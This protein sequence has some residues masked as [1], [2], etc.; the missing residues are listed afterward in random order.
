MMELSLTRS[1]RI[2]ALVVIFFVSIGSWASSSLA[3]ESGSTLSVA[4]TIS[5][6]CQEMNISVTPDQAKQWESDVRLRI[7]AVDNKIASIY[8]IPATSESSCLLNRA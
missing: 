2:F 1:S 3:F 5:D 6:V 7:Q 8:P 4:T